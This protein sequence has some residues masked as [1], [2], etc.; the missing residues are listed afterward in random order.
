[1]W[2]FLTPL[3]VERRVSCSTQSQASVVDDDR[4][5]VVRNAGRVPICPGACGSSPVVPLLGHDDRALPDGWREGGTERGDASQEGADF[6]HPCE[7]AAFS[8]R[9]FACLVLRPRWIIAVGSRPYQRDGPFP[10]CWRE[11][12][13]SRGRRSSREGRL[14]SRLRGRRLLRQGRS[15]AWLFAA[16]EGYGRVRLIQGS[17]PECPRAAVQGRSAATIG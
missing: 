6:A 7:G 12:T 13:A 3:A 15:A 8:R 11:G 16:L 10:G 5:I 2:R 4:R 9:A 17:C 1:M 14:H